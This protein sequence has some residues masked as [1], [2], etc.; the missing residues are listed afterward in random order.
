VAKVK[1]V[2][3]PDIGDFKDVDVIEVLVS[4]GDVVK[5]EDSLITL[6]SEKATMEVPSPEAG[7]VREV[8][9][10]VG[11][12]ISRGAPLLDLE[13]A[14]E[15]GPAAVEAGASK[16]AEEKPALPEEAAPKEAAQVEGAPKARLPSQAPQPRPRAE[17]RPA[18]LDEVA[19]A[20]A[21][22][23]PAVRRFARELGVDLGRVQASGPK[24]R[25]LKADVHAFVKT[26]LS[27]APASEAGGFAVPPPPEVDF[28]AFGEV[29]AVQLNKIRRLSGANLQRNWLSIPHVT[30]FDEAD[31]TELEAFRKAQAEEAARR[32]VKLTL[33]AFL[34]K[35][36][37]AALRQ[38]PE[39]NAS[40]AP[41]GD[42][43]ILKKYFHLGFAV[44]TPHGLVVPVVRNAD[45]MGLFELAQRLADMSARAR[46]RKLSPSDMQ[47][48]CFTVSSLGGIGGMA[49]TPIIN[50]PEV[51]ILG[52][53]RAVT[54]PV[55]KEGQFVPRLSLPFSV[56]YDHRVI[57]GAA[58]ARFT[59]Y[60][61]AV[62]S[63]VRRLL[64]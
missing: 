29:E 26:E 18:E 9:V 16:A 20:K 46:E 24:G 8:K 4:P 14:E 22:A 11:D 25:I 19:F 59:T 44:D 32:G 23:S 31:I 27:Q 42:S 53:S 41:G 49:F 56:S 35:A 10:K 13:L 58:G 33:L 43:L 34:M 2:L 7:T 47:G 6:E 51:A 50:A 17:T 1:E 30:Q 60:L 39:F 45:Q 40:L 3:L 28:S 12:R 54:K 55:Y 5:R 48:G 61:S 15:A 37:V 38:F 57:D 52:V 63:D 62:L 21:H 64:L 36:A